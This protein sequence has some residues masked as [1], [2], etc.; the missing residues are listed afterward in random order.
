[1]GKCLALR[2]AGPVWLWD[3]ISQRGNRVVETEWI[4]AVYTTVVYSSIPIVVLIEL[5]NPHCVYGCNPEIVF[6]AS[7]A[8]LDASIEV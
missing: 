4:F 6:N 2:V 3:V 7:Q 1:M 8:L 5:W